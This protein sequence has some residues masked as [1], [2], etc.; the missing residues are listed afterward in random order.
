MMDFYRETLGPLFSHDSTY[1][2]TLEGF[3]RCNGNLS[4]MART[5]HFHR[6]SLLYRLNRIEA[7]LGHSLEDPELRLSLQIALK[8]HHLQKY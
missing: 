2:D 5:M 8:I 6:N 1:I 7:L 3:F 4:E